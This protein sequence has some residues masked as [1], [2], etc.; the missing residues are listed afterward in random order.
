[1][2]KSLIFSFLFY[3]F[4][5]GPSLGSVN[6]IYPIDNKVYGEKLNINVEFEVEKFWPNTL[7]LNLLSSKNNDAALTCKAFL[8]LNRT[9]DYDRVVWSKNIKNFDTN[10]FYFFMTLQPDKSSITNLI[11]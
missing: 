8:D 5:S 9:D 10:K 11:V 7:F 1:M 4:L 2:K 3:F 6:I